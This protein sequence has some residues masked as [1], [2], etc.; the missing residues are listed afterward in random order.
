M[1]TVAS[2]SVERERPHRPVAA[3]TRTE[4]LGL[5]LIAGASLFVLVAGLDT[6]IPISEAGFLLMPIA[7]GGIGAAVAWRFGTVGR[8]IGL[9]LGIGA[10][11]LVFWLVF[12]LFVPASFV[13]F[14]SAVAFVLG[15]GLLLYG[16]V[17]SLVRRDVL[18]TEPT[19][20][21]L[22]L[23]RSALAIVAL[24]LLV[25]LPLWA[26]SRT[27]VDASAASGL[28]EATAANFAFEDVT[29]AA[30]DGTVTMV[31]RNTDAFSHT[32]TI[33]SLGVDVELLPRSSQLVT[34][35][36]APGAY[37]YY[38]IPHSSAAGDDE[39]DMA[40]TLTVQ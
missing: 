19:R 27:T 10:A 25:S 14:T 16:G 26:M 39:H 15:V 2:P 21:E 23:D 30:T 3:H 38:C 17:A 12:G 40:A 8:S 1:S 13:E 36:A 22:L 6:G 28:A 7:A 33:D 11:F 37:T 9:A 24:T 18:E 29:V 31:V 20:S 5:L 34:F 4:V 32:F 35:D